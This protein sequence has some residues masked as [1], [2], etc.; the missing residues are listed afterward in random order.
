MNILFHLCCANCAIYPVRVLREKNLSVTGFFFNNNIHP[1]Q[2]F[3]RRLDTV[4][5]YAHRVELDV[6]INE[7]Y[8]LESFLQQVAANPAKRCDY[9]YLSRL[10]ET[11]RKAAELGFDAFSSSLLYSRYQQ[12]DRI[13]EF[14]ENLAAKY[15]ISFFYEDFRQG[16][17]EGIQMSKSMGLYRQ[18]YCG[19]IY[20]EMDRYSPRSRN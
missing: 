9:C 2:E 13:R 1:Y 14:G 20:S 8:M 7:D 18:Q 6:Q 4:K 19:C 15:E 16:W 10:E 11:A 17:Q 3:R 12:H 5:E